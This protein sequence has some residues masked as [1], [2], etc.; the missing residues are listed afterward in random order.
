[1]VT[2]VNQNYLENK[3]L[4]NK[5]EVELRK[6]LDKTIPINHVGSTAIPEMCGKN[7]IDILVGAS[8]GKQFEELIIYFIAKGY[9]ASIK[10]KTE[11]YQFFSSREGETESGDTHIH[12]VMLGTQKYDEFIILRDYLLNNK[13]EALKYS[14]LKK[15]LIESGIVERKQYKN[16]KSEYVT[17]LLERAKEIM[18]RKF[19]MN[20]LGTKTLD[21]ERLILRK[22]EEK[23][24]EELYNGYMNQEEF[25][26]Y[27]HK[28]TKTI[29]EIQ[30]IIKNKL[31]RYQND[32]Y[33]NWVITL[34][35]TGNVIGAINL[36]VDNHNDSVQFN[37]AIDNRYT[38]KG[39]M[40]EALN[41]MKRFCLNDLKVNR[42]QG[43]CCIE[44]I[45]SKRVMEK[46][47]MQYEGTLRSYINLK[48]GYHDMHM[49][50]II[51]KASK[52]DENN[53]LKIFNIK[54]KQEFIE[55]VAILTEIEWGKEIG[56]PEEFDE[57]V[58]RK[59]EKI[60]SRLD[61]ENYCKLILLDENKLVGFISIFPH[62]GDER[63]DLSP[64]YATMY[65]KDEYRG[66]G[67]SKILN[68]A[69]LEEARNRG[70]EKLYLKSEL[71]NYYEKFGAKYM[72]TL[73]NGE[74]LYYIEIEKKEH[75]I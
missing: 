37:Y 54:D 66:K 17:K 3:N 18:E 32:D 23:D 47:G 9:R 73:E 58:N 45:A 29:E 64:W 55:E 22:F 14:N 56:T 50:S 19:I 51:S 48:D 72:E 70:F 46:C 25:L 28:E 36:N 38:N 53:D 52:I 60:I 67:Y 75:L 27:A 11:I 10:S 8:D 30:E 12:L 35:E 40:T 4:Y 15:E 57:R 43:G 21:T 62:D 16:A 59:I 41:E 69:I 26:Y 1:M 5:I 34:K 13:D 42:F 49:F 68:D 44:N 20:N 7:I 61:A 65:V 63:Q 24:A 39:Y 33:Y 74:K 2:L 71:E 6:D 31:E